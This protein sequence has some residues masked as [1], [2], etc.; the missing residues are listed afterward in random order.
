MGKRAISAMARVLELEVHTEKGQPI[1]REM[2]FNAMADV[3]GGEQKITAD[4]LAQE[5]IPC[6]REFRDRLD[7]RE[8]LTSSLSE[9][10]CRYMIEFIWRGSSLEDTLYCINVALLIDPLSITAYKPLA[11]NDAVPPEIKER[12]VDAWIEMSGHKVLSPALM[13]KG[14][15]LLKM[16]KFSMA[17]NCFSRVATSED[18]E[19][20]GSIPLA[21]LQRGICYMKMDLP[22]LALTNFETVIDIAPDNPRILFWASYYRY[23]LLEEMGR[24]TEAAEMID[25]MLGIHAADAIRMRD[26]L[27]LEKAVLC[28][29]LGKNSEAL[30]IGRMALERGLTD[31]QVMDV[32]RG[33]VCGVSNKAVGCDIIQ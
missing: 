23:D 9:I 10:Y 18:R 11:G 26:S 2:L 15:C 22:N 21:L 1:P 3:A 20:N 14:E 16:G 4:M 17:E 13:L 27:L 8:L 33:I 6:N 12:Y 5:G 28:F 31:K 29:R 24:L 30:R 32:I 19:F 7:P 25:V